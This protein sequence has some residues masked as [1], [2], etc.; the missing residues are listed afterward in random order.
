L[1]ALRRDTPAL[2][3]GDFVPLALKAPL[4]GF[5]RALG[6]TRVRCLFNL[7]D[8]PVRIAADGGRILYARGAAPGRLE[9]LGIRLSASTDR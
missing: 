9:P 7:G 3:Q 1:I 5:E 2:R 8:A 4:L 6:K